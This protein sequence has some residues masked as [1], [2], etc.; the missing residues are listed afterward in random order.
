M[1]EHFK[2]LFRRDT[3]LNESDFKYGS[4]KT[5]GTDEETASHDQV[6]VPEDQEPTDDVKPQEQVV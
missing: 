4:N 1:R 3:I 5:K 6:V 2:I